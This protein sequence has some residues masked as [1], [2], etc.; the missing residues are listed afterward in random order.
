V[1][2]ENDIISTS[3]CRQ[4][5]LV[6]AKASSPYGSDFVISPPGIGLAPRGH[7]IPEEYKM[8]QYYLHRS[9]TTQRN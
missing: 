7:S 4:N 6:N 2:N 5:S 9:I 3:L 8:S 1:Q